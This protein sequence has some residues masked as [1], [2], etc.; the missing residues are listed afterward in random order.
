MTGYGSS[1]GLVN[2]V[3]YAVEIRSVNHR[4]FKAVVKLPE[5]LAS[6]ESP[7]EQLLREALYRGTVTV[8]VRMRLGDDQA[9]YRVNT[10]AL[11]NY[12]EQLKPLEI[13]ANPM[14]RMDLG[15]LLQLPGVCQPP[16][17][18]DL[19]ERTREGLM[20]LIRQALDQL[21][22]MRKREGK[23]LKADLLNQCKVIREN[24]KEVIVRAPQMV[25]EYRDRLLAR[26]ND[27]VEEGELN[28]DNDSLAREVAIYAE[29]CDIAEESPG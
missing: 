3:E 29:R 27:L 24:L 20:E 23:T 12:M 17:L 11:T 13:D 1:H 16:P 28:I 14:L 10:A 21:L 5:N 7:V 4:Y 22:E 9:A 8:T 26:V 15:T 2:G 19:L 25:I 18:E 6:A